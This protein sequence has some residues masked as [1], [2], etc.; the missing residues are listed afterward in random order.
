[1]CDVHVVCVG[2]VDAM[3]RQ[4]N[5]IGAPLQIWLHA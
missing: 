2:F 1:M 3:P 5:F 4:E